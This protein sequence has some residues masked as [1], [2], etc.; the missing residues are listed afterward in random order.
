MDRGSS[1]L[2]VAA[3][4]AAAGGCLAL[5]YSDGGGVGLV[6]LESKHTQGLLHF[7][8][9]CYIKVS[10]AWSSKYGWKSQSFKSY[11][12]RFMI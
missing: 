3:A 11:L 9:A 4:A 10:R 1:S 12:V 2:V 8:V 5:C 6:G 7:M